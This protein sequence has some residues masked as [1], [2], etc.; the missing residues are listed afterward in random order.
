MKEIEHKLG[1]DYL[2]I[3]SYEGKHINNVTER[4]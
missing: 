4:G 3:A 2:M 1:F